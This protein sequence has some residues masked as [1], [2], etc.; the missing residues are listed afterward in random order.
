M[1]SNVKILMKEK[2]VTILALADECGFSSRTIQKAR[3]ERIESCT[4]RTLA[5]IASALGCQVKDLFE[6]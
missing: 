1:K 3:D 5:A 2:G 6:E 4:L